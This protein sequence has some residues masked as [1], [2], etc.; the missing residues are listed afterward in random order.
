MDAQTLAVMDAMASQMEA[1]KE[2]MEMAEA[3]I[4]ELQTRREC[5]CQTWR[6]HTGL[7]REIED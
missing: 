7:P 5:S 3:R 6:E 4:K 2:R 1:L